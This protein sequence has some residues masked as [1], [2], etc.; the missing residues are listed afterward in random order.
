LVAA[1]E[2]N[3]NAEHV[4]PGDEALKF[5]AAEW[6]AFTEKEKQDIL[7]NYRLA[8][9]G[10]GE[11]NWCEALG[12]VLANDEVVNGVSE[13]G[14]FPVV[15]KKLRQWYLRITEY[16]DRLLDGLKTIEFSEAMT[17]MQS[18]WIGKSFGAEIQFKIQNSE[19][20]IDVY[21]TRPDTIFGVDFMVV[22][23]EH[24]LIPQI[25]PARPPGSC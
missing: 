5:S 1:F 22:A 24:E 10:F 12:T 14:G 2:K 19:F 3:G 8:Y 9:C 20:K 6:K 18:N 17:E 21:T 13:R 4:C 7:M 23:P 16:A 15:K 25:T 11:V